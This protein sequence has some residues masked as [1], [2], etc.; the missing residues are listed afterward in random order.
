M[1]K[2]YNHK[3]ENDKIIQQNRDEYNYE[4]NN[5]LKVMDCIYI[6]KKGGLHI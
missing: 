3:F 5:T 2:L 1:D 4:Y 6:L